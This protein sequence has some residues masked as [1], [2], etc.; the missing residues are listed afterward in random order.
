MYPVERHNSQLDPDEDRMQLQ[1]VSG[2]FR[3]EWS[4]L[5][6]VWVL[7]VIMFVIILWLAFRF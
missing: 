6:P 5:W 1:R 2:F 3:G 4:N 7:G